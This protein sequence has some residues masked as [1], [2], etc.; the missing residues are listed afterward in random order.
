MVG[1]ADVLGA[2]FTTQSRPYPA[3]LQSTNMNFNF[4]RLE[5]CK[6]NLGNGTNVQVRVR[7]DSICV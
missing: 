4:I 7:T 3:Q 6:K 5:L 2:Q 1:T